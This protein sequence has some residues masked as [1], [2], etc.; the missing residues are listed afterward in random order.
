MGLVRAE[1]GIL[2][3]LPGARGFLFLDRLQL[4][5]PFDEQQVGHLLYDL[6]G[7]GDAAA[8]ECVPDLVNLGFNGACD[9][10][11]CLSV[12]KFHVIADYPPLAG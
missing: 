7:V 1:N 8:P 11:V 3:G 12:M 10:C 6:H 5:Q 2:N 9:Q 4:I